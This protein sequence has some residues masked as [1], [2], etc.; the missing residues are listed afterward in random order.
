M[1]GKGISLRAPLPGQLYSPITSF[2][3]PCQNPPFPPTLKAPHAPKISTPFT[4]ANKSFIMKK[5]SL[6]KRYPRP[7]ARPLPPPSLDLPLSILSEKKPLSLFHENISYLG[8]PFREVPDPTA[9]SSPR[10]K[11]TWPSPPPPPHPAPSCPPSPGWGRRA[12]RALRA[13]DDRAP[14]PGSAPAA[15]SAG[16]RA[17][18]GGGGEGCSSQAQGCGGGALGPRGG[19]GAARRWEA[20]GKGDS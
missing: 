7:S 3:N 20:P 1:S 18:R 11:E 10:I 15:R 12:D 16:G 8:H 17:W 19:R 9:S 13:G 14:A 2:F 6:K 4:E 5:K